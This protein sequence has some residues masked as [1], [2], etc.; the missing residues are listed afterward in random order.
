MRKQ[1]NRR[2]WQKDPAS[3]YRVMARLQ[4]FTTPEQDRINLPVRESMQSLRDGTATDLD[5]DR[6]AAITNVCV[7]RG[8]QID[9]LVLDVAKDGQQAILDVLARYERTGKWGVSHADMVRLDTCIDLHEQ[10]VALSTPEQMVQSMRETIAR[11]N[12]GEV[13]QRKQ[14]EAL[15]E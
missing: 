3:I 13:L 8:E 1:N 2:R 11:C 6:L 9:P 10:L 4:P 7:L 12:Q 15:C 5:W 14:H